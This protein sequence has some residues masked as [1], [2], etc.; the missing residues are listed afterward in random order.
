MSNPQEFITDE[1]MAKFDIQEN[2]Q[3]DNPL[4]FALFGL[5]RDLPVWE[6]VDFTKKVLDL[7]PGKKMIPGAIRCEYPEYN[8]ESIEFLNYPVQGN[9]VN[10]QHQ[11]APPGEFDFDHVAYTDGNSRYRQTLPFAN[12]S[13]GGIFAVH[14]LEHLWDPRP[15]LAECQRVLAPGCPLNIVVPNGLSKIHFQDVDHKKPYVLDSWDNLYENKYYDTN[16][17]TGFRVGTNFKFAVKEGNEVLVTQL[18]KYGPQ[19]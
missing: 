14:M 16:R 10:A 2:P 8:F 13:V 18:I 15:I 9:E 12:D 5:A 7:G 17:G 6:P 3:H 11:I 1:W 19:G 4:D